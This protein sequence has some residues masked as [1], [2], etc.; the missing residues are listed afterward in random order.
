MSRF[1]PTKS[2]WTCPAC[3]GLN[4]WAY[5]DYEKLESKGKEVYMCHG[6]SFDNIC[7]KCGTDWVRR[8]SPIRAEVYT[9]EPSK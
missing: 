5:E 6:S 1:N 4:V 9:H 2:R 8:D 7:G 3:G